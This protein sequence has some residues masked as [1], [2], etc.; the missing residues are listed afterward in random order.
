MGT[1][2]LGQCGHKSRPLLSWSVLTRLKTRHLEVEMKSILVATD[3]SARSD[4]ALER[5]VQLADLHKAS[6]TIVHV[7][8]EG[9]PASIADEQARAARQAILRHAEALRSVGEPS[10]SVEVVFGRPH[11]DIL[12]MSDQV[13]AD[14][15]VLGLHR[16]HL[17]KDMFRG[18]TAERVIRAGNTPVLLVKDRVNAPYQGVMVGVDFSVYS[19]RA[20]EVAMSFAPNSL[21]HLVHAYDV[22]FEDILRATKPQSEVSKQ[23]Q[24]QT[25]EMIEEEMRVFFSTVDVQSSSVERIMEQGMPRQVIHEQVEKLKPDLLVVGTHG[26]TGVSHA[27]LGSIAEDLLRDPPCDVLAVNAW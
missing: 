26:R 16:E 1:S 19:R 20:V 21:F 6:L 17:L 14:L 15:I 12:E 8:D 27:F 22:P 25:Q 18:T 3:L 5:A 23:L 2:H 13:S 11:V 7:V 10:I 4:R 24:L 9:L